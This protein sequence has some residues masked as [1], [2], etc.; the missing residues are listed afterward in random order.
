MADNSLRILQSL[1]DLKSIRV[2][3]LDTFRT[4][5]SKWRASILG[6][7]EEV[8]SKAAETGTLLHQ[9]IED[10]LFRKFK[11][12]TNECQDIQIML[13]NAGVPAKERLA[14]ISYLQSI[15]PY[16]ER[17]KA[18]EYEFKLQFVENAPPVV[19]HID[20]LLDDD[21]GGITIID[22]KSNRTYQEV[23]YWKKQLQL[24]FYAG[25]VHC[26]WPN[27]PHIRCQIGYILLNETVNWEFTQ[28]EIR[29][30]LHYLS[31]IYHEFI[32]EFR[33]YSRTSEFPERVNSH[34]KYC[35]VKRDCRTLQYQ[36]LE[37]LNSFWSKVK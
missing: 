34:C 10:Y 11:L 15:T 13:E 36:H 27:A 7:G 18:V 12:Y 30:Y 37:F 14:L 32:E 4:C 16:R 9:I 5:P 17:I 29:N 19:G 8:K 31:T 20:L 28:D 24:Q 25:A 3:S 26:I 35:S 23:N 21:D 1:D 33:V 22:H 2:T 6:Y